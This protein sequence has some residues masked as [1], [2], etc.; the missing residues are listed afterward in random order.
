MLVFRYL[1]LN[2]PINCLKCFMDRYVIVTGVEKIATDI[3][4]FWLVNN[5]IKDKV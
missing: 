5:T 2:I 3:N 1:G 4:N